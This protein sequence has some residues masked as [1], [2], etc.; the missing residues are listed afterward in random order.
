M[1]KKAHCGRL[2]RMLGKDQYRQ[3]MW[4][5]FSLERVITY[6]FMKNAEKVKQEGIQGQWQR[7]SPAKEYLEQVKSSADTDCTPKVMRCGYYALKD[8]DREEHKS[9]FKVEISAAEWAFE[10]M[11]EAFEQVAKYEARRINIV[12]RIQ[13]KSTDSCRVS[14]RQPEGQGGVTLSYLCTNCN[15]FL[16]EDFMWWVSAGKKHCRWWCAIC[17][18]NMIGERPPGYWWYKQVPVPIR[19]RCSKRM[20]YR[21]VCVKTWSMRSSCWR[22]SRKIEIAQSKVLLQAFVKEAGKELWRA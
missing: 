11:R 20:R 12:Q 17:R 21:K 18:E 6:K 3:G 8:G 14:S 1:E 4:E 19:Q 10:R 16:L 15:S 13:L 5:Y 7:E 22:T 9:I 2:W